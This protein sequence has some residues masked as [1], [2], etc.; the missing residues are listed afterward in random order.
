M[1][2][3]NVK[4][5][6]MK[7]I[8][9]ITNIQKLVLFFVSLR[10]FVIFILFFWC[11]NNARLPFLSFFF[12]FLDFFQLF[13]WKPR[14]RNWEIL[15]TSENLS[16]RKKWTKIIRCERCEWQNAVFLIRFFFLHQNRWTSQD[17]RGPI[18]LTRQKTK[19]EIFQTSLNECKSI[20]NQGILLLSIFLLYAHLDHVAL[21][22]IKER[23]RKQRKR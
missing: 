5:M 1:S 13:L 7:M 15:T 16:K 10:F 18:D 8:K 22:K 23:F 4:G 3:I 9:R 12:T 19:S 20:W 6:R 11:H 21:T 17:T 14:K 2:G